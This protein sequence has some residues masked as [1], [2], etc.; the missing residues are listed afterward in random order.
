LSIKT[1]KV[2]GVI[3][4]WCGEAKKSELFPAF[5]EILQMTPNAI[6]ASATTGNAASFFGSPQLR[7]QNKNFK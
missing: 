3:S 1:Q 4:A 5:L 6:G 7:G 2:T